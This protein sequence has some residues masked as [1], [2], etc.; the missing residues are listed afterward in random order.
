MASN[1]QP[2][3]MK[4]VQRAEERVADTAKAGPPVEGDMPFVD[5]RAASDFHANL[6]AAQETWKPDFNPENAKPQEGPTLR[7]VEGERVLAEVAIGQIRS[8]ARQRI[9]DLGSDEIRA[10]LPV[11]VR[12]PEEHENIAFADVRGLA[13]GRIAEIKAGGEANKLAA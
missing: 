9:M 2:V 5:V 11:S 4:L 7:L 8:D 12:T 1:D 3:I 6:A 10:R 13:L